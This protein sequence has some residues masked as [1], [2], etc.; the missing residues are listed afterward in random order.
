MK[1]TCWIARDIDGDIY[2]HFEKPSEDYV[3]PKFWRSSDYVN[4][5]KT[6]LDKIHSNITPGSEPVEFII[7]KSPLD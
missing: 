5:S 6:S 3:T 7:Q 4:V 1:K 2:I